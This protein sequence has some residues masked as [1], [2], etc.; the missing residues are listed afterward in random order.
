MRAAFR[1]DVGVI[2]IKVSC[3]VIVKRTPTFIYLCDIGWAANLCSKIG[4]D[5]MLHCVMN[6]AIILFLFRCCVRL[7]QRPFHWFFC[8]FVEID[9]I[10]Q[11]SIRFK[12]FPW[13]FHFD[14]RFVGSVTFSISCHLHSAITIHITYSCSRLHTFYIKNQ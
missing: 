12:D 10:D 8:W 6:F 3:F 9:L 5:C 13:N 2:W 11:H 7:W 1:I 14:F 4:I